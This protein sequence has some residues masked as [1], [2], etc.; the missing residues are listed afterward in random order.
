MLELVGVSQKESRRGLDPVQLLQDISLKAPAGHVLGIIGPARSGKTTLAKIL[1]GIMAP[2]QGAVLWK[3][4]DSRKHPL[5][6]NQVGFVPFGDDDVP[7][8]LTVREN[9]ISAAL[10]RLDGVSTAEARERADEMIILTGLETAARKRSRNLNLPQ[11]RRLK[12]AL[13][14]VSNP[15]VVICDGFTD[16]IDARSARELGALLKEVAA[17]HPARLVIH[18]TDDL[19]QVDSHHSVLLLH[20][21]YACYHGPVRALTHYF[22]IK[23]PLELFAKLAQRPGSRWGESW[24]RHRDSY[25]KTFKLGESHEKLASA[26]DDDDKG[27]PDRVRLPSSDKETGESSTESDDSDESTAKD[28]NSKG[29]TSAPA[30]P[31]VPGPVTQA[32]HLMRRR[33][34]L[35][36]RRR[37]EWIEA[38]LLILGSPLLICLL[39]WPYHD[40]LAGTT[41]ASTS[42]QSAFACF[43]GVFVQ[44]LLVLFGAVRFASREIAFDRA[45]FD[46]ERIGGVASLAHVLAKLGLVIP[47]SVIQCLAINMFTEMT[48]GGLP[49]HAFARLVLLVLSGVAFTFICLG[50]SSNSKSSARSLGI[51]LGLLFANVILSGAL[52]APPRIIGGVIQPFCTAYYGWSGALDAMHGTSVFESMTEL[53]PT[54]FA[55]PAF[56][57][58]M[59]LVH[60][61]V[62]LSLIV[63]GMRRGRPQFG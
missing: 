28:T 7:D 41:E 61:L 24:S 10:L 40:V 35:F 50:I 12:M 59:L 3:G 29:T 20:D 26:S 62:G 25:Y 11:R 43:M 18:A 16:R 21:G 47:L 5:H 49:G 4:S 51:C 55:T 63:I 14:L 36:R 34:T 19:T 48:S 17:H 57:V 23:T 30:V 9:V 22:S 6:R 15:S 38:L 13:A 31:E 27:S 32:R 46:R 52:L 2:T 44:T 53:V 8:D 42:L 37:A 58:I 33:W 1:T 60:A 39:I 45:V 56:A 54:W